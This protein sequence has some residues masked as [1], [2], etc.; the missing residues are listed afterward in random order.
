MLHEQEDGQQ[1][2]DTTVSIEERVQ[3]LELV[4]QQGVLD[5]QWNLGG[6][7]CVALPVGQQRWEFFWRRWD[8]PC[9]LDGRSTF[10]DPVLGRAELARR[11]LATPHAGEQ[12]SVHLAD[13]TNTE[14]EFAQL[15]EAPFEGI[16]VVE[17]LLDVRIWGLAACFSF[18]YA[19]A[20]LK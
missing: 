3:R 7:V 17:D 16:D 12:S 13:E 20:S 18:E 4:V 5:E 9:C 1:T 6:L 10:P 15:A 14:R 8:K 2:A 11:P 19:L